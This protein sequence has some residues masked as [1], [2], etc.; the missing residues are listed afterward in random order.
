MNRNGANGYRSPAKKK[1]MRVSN[2]NLEMT[3]ISRLY[4]AQLTIHDVQAAKKAEE[5][6]TDTDGATSPSKPASKKRGRGKADNIQEKPP[7][8]KAKTSSKKALKSK[9]EDDAESLG[10]SA[11]SEV[12]TPFKTTPKAKRSSTARE[13]KP[14][15]EEEEKGTVLNGRVTG[16]SLSRKRGPPRKAKSQVHVAD[17]ESDAENSADSASEAVV[18]PVKAGRG[19]KSKNAK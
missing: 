19:R 17:E 18:E 1:A 9:V 7:K 11:T 13:K 10:N 8:K 2:R 15:I 4:T 5:A 12:E 3:L 6:G 14:V 16:K